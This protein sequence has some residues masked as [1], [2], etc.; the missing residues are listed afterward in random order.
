MFYET[1]KLAVQAVRRNALRSFLTLL[2]IVIGVCAVIAMVTIGNGTTEKVKEEMAK[3]GSNV[4]FIR[5][6]QWG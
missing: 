6:G 1:L 3:L 4:L 5:P 2:G